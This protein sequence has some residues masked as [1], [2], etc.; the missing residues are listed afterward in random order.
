MFVGVDNAE[1]VAVGVVSEGSDVFQVI[2]DFR[3]TAQGIVLAFHC[4]VVVVGDADCI[5]ALVV[6][7]LGAAAI[8]VDHRRFLVHGVVFVF[9]GVAV[10]VGLTNQVAGLVVSESGDVA[11]NVGGADA[12]VGGVVLM[13]GFGADRVAARC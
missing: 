10:G 4:F 6:N 11:Q 7:G 8:G 5:A 13:D 12:A 2:G 3:H 1:L 9:C